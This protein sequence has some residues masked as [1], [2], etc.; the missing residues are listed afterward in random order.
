MGYKRLC[1]KKRK[2]WE[3]PLMAS[4]QPWRAGGGASGVSSVYRP[5]K[6]TE[7]IRKT[8]LRRCALVSYTDHPEHTVE[9]VV[10][11][12]LQGCYRGYRNQLP[13]PQGLWS[14]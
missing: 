1:L 13:F 12:R 8:V 11:G 4:L 6:A 2:K 7:A 10:R 14:P 9:R 5:R 3:W